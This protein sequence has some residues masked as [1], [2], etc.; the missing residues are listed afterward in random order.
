VDSDIALA[1]SELREQWLQLSKDYAQL[2]AAP[3]DPAAA[4]AHLERLRRHRERLRF[5]RSSL[6]RSSGE[7]D[8]H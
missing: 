1:F 6:R 7:S 5:L 3:Y 8:V 4:E 2:V